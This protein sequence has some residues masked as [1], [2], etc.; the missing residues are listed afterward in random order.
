MG[1][2]TPKKDSS[3]KTESKFTTAVN[4]EKKF[5]GKIFSREIYREISLESIS[6]R[7]ENSRQ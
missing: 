3:G 2:G 7:N 4:S 5:P 6:L 1:F